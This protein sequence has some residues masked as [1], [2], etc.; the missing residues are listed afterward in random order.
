M[1]FSR[2]RRAI[3]CATVA[4]VATA[5]WSADVRRPDVVLVVVDTLRADRLG[6]WGNRRGLTP[7]LDELAGRAH[8]FT[9]AYAQAP[10]TNPSVASL[11]TSR[12]QSQH[13]ITEFL[14][15]LAADE[16]TLA[17]A[18]GEAGWATGG[19]S[20][21]GLLSRRAGFDQGFDAYRSFLQ[22][23]GAED[24]LLRPAK[25]AD[26]ITAEGMRWL[27]EVRASRPDVPV[28]LYLHYMEPHT[29]YAPPPA[30]LERVRGPGAPL[31]LGA[32]NRAV[33]LANLTAPAPA[34]LRDIQDAY[35]AEVLA[36]DEGLRALAAALDA[37]GLLETSLLVVT[38]DH[39][40]EFQEHGGMG[41]G[42][43]LYDEVLHVPL[44]IRTPGQGRGVVVDRLV[45]SVDVAPT[46]LEVAGVPPRPTFEGVSLARDLTARGTPSSLRRWL[47]RLFDDRP[48]PV[49]FSERRPQQAGAVRGP[50]HEDAVVSGWGKVIRSSD[51]SR[52]FYALDVDPGERRPDRVDE[53]EREHLDDRLRA[54]RARAERNRTPAETHAIDERTRG[55]LRALGYAD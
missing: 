46:I 25:R 3:L 24:R 50:T 43:T 33:V 16:Q 15:V 22:L 38:A 51:G 28:F 7:F 42:R 18:L 53:G 21:N 30:L 23:G 39:G 6:A 41:H 45:S 47:A 12:Y 52:A 10:W 17:E 31:D 49:V 27:D 29:P 8:V 9:R 48:A 54:M 55:M 11:F 34:V 44:V 32:L 4:L 19:F 35:D 37:R 36:I 2:A 40:E 13:G 5:A 20:A 14:S 1:P 26:E